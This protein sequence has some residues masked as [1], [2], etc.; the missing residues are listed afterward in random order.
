MTTRQLAITFEAGGDPTACGQ[1]LDILSQTG[2]PATIFLWGHWSEQYPELVRRISECGHEFGNHSYTHPDL[3]QCDDEQVRDELRRTDAL[4]VSLTG[5]HTIPWLRPPY[6]AV[7]ERVRQ[8]AILEGYQL[9]QRSALDGGHYPP[10]AATPALVRSRSLEH[11]Y[12]GAVLTYHLDSPLTVSVLA[13]IIGDLRAAGY[14]LVRLSELPLVSERPERLPDF[15]SLA[16]TPG[17]LQVLRRGAPAWSLNVLEYGARVSAPLGSPVPLVNSG[18]SPVS[19]LTS[20]GGEEV[21]PAG[22]RDRYLLV[23]AGRVE[24]WFHPRGDPVPRVRA[25]GCPGDLILW[26]KD[27]ELRTGASP[28]AWIVLIFE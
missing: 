18:S 5:Q 25:V 6:D 1:M 3:T 24:C 21:Q 14:E 2:V 7:D 27:V 8:I 26:A 28:Q 11:A 20:S 17:Y 13:D 22:G 12:E 23:M 9:V 10:G 16:A 19:I 4:A 15:A